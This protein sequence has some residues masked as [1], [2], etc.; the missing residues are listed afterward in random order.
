MTV[1]DDNRLYQ[2][3]NAH[4]EKIIER[5]GYEFFY[6]KRALEQN[7]FETSVQQVCK[8]LEKIKRQNH[9]VSST[10]ECNK[11]IVYQ[12]KDALPTYLSSD[13]FGREKQK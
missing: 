11:R 5:N 7:D 9:E 6:K 10:K 12:K 3:D 1:V 13:K 2:Q 4:A 8:P